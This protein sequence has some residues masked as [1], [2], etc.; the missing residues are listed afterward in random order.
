MTERFEYQQ[1]EKIL[2]PAGS[3]SAFRLPSL[4]EGRGE[5]ENQPFPL[6]RPGE[7]EIQEVFDLLS[8]NQNS[9]DFPV[10]GFP[11]FTKT[12][13]REIRRMTFCIIWVLL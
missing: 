8:I 13:N 1:I 3:A 5:G 7:G 4:R 6:S 2:F 12:G 10:P 9:A 11:G